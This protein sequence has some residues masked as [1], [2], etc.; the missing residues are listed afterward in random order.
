MKKQKSIT[1]F[2]IVLYI[3]ILYFSPAAY[4]NKPKFFFLN[5]VRFP[6]RLM[7]HTFY[8]LSG[9][10]RSK[11]LVRENIILQRTV[12]SLTHQIVKYKDAEVENTR[13]RKLLGFK[14]DSSFSL[15]VAS[16]IGRDSS[17][18]SDTI[19]IDKGKKSGVKEE[20]VVIAEAGLAGRVFSN[21]SGMSKVIL[22]TDPHS[23]VSGVVLR[24]R[25]S[26][27]VYGISSRLCK[28][29]YLPLDADIMLGDEVMT[30]GISDIYPKGILIGRVVKIV[31]EPRGLSLSALIQPA[32][33]ISKTEEVLCIMK[34]T[35]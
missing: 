20:T 3:A 31:R 30:S 22:I 32:V 13:L 24:S 9:L 12:D 19:L 33:D 4:I 21:S 23:R 17:N 7:H 10:I 14:Q 29:K 26:G 27:M 25:Q 28:L 5:I 1:V 16:V 2:I 8:N 18:L 11:D 35:T 34:P 6:L 15:I